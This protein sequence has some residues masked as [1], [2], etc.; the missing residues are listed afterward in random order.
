MVDILRQKQDLLID[1]KEAI[2]KAEVLEFMHNVREELDEHRDAINNDTNEIQTNYE[3]ICGLNEKIEKLSERL[4]KLNL[5]LKGSVEAEDFKISPLTKK[6]KEVFMALYTL[7][8]SR[9]FVT[10]KDMAKSLCMTESLVSNYIT[11]IVE[12]GIP[13]LKKYSG[14][15]V[16]LKLDDKFREKQAKENIVGVNTLLSYWMPKGA[17]EHTD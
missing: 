5:L 14:G 3:Y 11:N 7:G 2:F 8:Q 17:I 15:M 12:K 10:Y 9:S 13:V 16:Y 4:D 6:E 1:D